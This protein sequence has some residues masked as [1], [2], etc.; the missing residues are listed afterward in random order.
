M[1]TNLQSD[2]ELVLGHVYGL[3]QWELYTPQKFVEGL[4]A[5]FKDPVLKGHVGHKWLPAGVNLAACSTNNKA[6]YKEFTV[7]S[8]LSP[9]LIYQ[10]V[11]NY[12]RQFLVQNPEA[13]HVKIAMP[14]ADD[15][16][17]QSI[18]PD[19]PEIF[20]LPDPLSADS[21]YYPNP[22]ITTFRIAWSEPIP[23]HVVTAPEHTCGF[24]AYT[25]E[26]SLFENSN[27]GANSVFGLIKAYGHVT[28]GTKGFRAEKAEIVALTEPLD[29][30]ESAEGAL[31]FT[32]DGAEVPSRHR[33]HVPA[34]DSDALDRFR[35][36]VPESI[37]TYGNLSDMLAAA[38]PLLV[39]QRG[40]K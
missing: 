16:F 28:Q 13:T 27:R 2:T 26:A 4:P 14:Y 23:P 6:K 20:R 37:E 5:G 29:W 22:M 15:D 24:Y 32:R 10:G 36:I 11:S 31:F 21:D 40:E 1:C 18:R 9:F 39:D 12:L 35:S 7:N 25:D 34:V 19:A 38:R 30:V 33:G 8:S 17:Y 3:R